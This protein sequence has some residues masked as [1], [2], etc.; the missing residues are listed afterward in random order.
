VATGSGIG[1]E[2]ERRVT[3]ET[4]SDRQA[5]LDEIRRVIGSN[6]GE[7]VQCDKRLRFLLDELSRVERERDWYKPTSQK[8]QWNA[9]SNELAAE[10]VSVT[11]ERDAALADA[12]SQRLRVEEY[13]REVERRDELLAG[14]DRDR[15]EARRE[16][17]ALEDVNMNLVAQRDEAR[18]RVGRLRE[19]LDSIAN[20]RRH[21]GCEPMATPDECLAHAERLADAALAETKPEPEPERKGLIELGW[22]DP[23][24][25][26]PKP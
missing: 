9:R 23:L 25:P 14:A 1:Q 15:D 2:S 13:Q 20:H 3:H 21:T 12:A 26:E 22:F 6:H 8:A 10:L 19:A 18:E 16:A 5:R 11:A 24:K 17:D 4:E 7:Y